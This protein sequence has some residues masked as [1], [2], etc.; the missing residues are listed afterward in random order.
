MECT[1]KFYAYFN[2]SNIQKLF[3][4]AIIKILPVS[5]RDSS[6]RKEALI[7]NGF[8]YFYLLKLLFRRRNLL[9]RWN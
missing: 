1:N 3:D 5:K 2:E 6:E 9:R 8:N 7:E 4:L